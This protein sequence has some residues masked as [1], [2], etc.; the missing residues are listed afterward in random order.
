MVAALAA[1]LLVVL[2]A[3][4]VT[5][6]TAGPA[7]A[8]AT[9]VSTSPAEGEVLA[10]APEQITL[11]FSEPVSLAADGVAVF[12][13]KGAPV[14]ASATS[15]DEQ[16]VAEFDDPGALAD[17]TYVVTWRVISADG[18][19]VAGS[20]TF[21][22]GAPSPSVATPE[23]P[24]GS[25]GAVRAL[26]SVATAVQY[27]G[28]LLAAGL[29]L[30]LTV[31][32]RRQPRVDVAARRLGVVA[33]AAAA[34]GVLGALATLPL[35]LAY[36]SGASVGGVADRETWSAVTTTDLVGTTALLVALGLVALGLP[37]AV[38]RG[39]RTVVQ[40]AALVALVVPTL[41]GH[42]RAFGPEV[43]MV[44][45]DVLHLAAAAI[46]LGG[47]VGLAVTLPSL[48]GRARAA[49]E[50]L[51]RFSTVAAGALLAL[52]AAGL[53]MSWRIVVSWDN[54]TGTDYG[55]LLAA[56]VTLVAVVVAIAAWNRFDLVPEVARSTGHEDGRRAVA[57]VRRSVVAEAAVLVAVVA[58]TGF[59]VNQ[60]P[61]TTLPPVPPGRS[62]TESAV[63]GDVT[64]FATLTPGRTG[65]N[66]L[67]V[68]L[69]DASGEPL[70]HPLPP[71]VRVSSDAVDLGDVPLTSADAGTFS[72]E[73][74]LPSPGLWEVQ[75]G[76]RLSQFEN[77]VGV[78]TFEVR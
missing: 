48:A 4:A 2:G 71:T 63:L 10:D 65:R 26:L 24:T 22:I 1:G 12:D 3:F 39:Q 37:R 33:R 41:T 38:T 27:A 23:P 32:L 14:D 54:L 31:L 52:T 7:A 62:G 40:V 5:L 67:L 29:V 49:A 56:K 66:T 73:V 35:S 44:A 74:T 58:V 47:L 60:T 69:Q 36:R 34:V 6:G 21:S 68:Q 72:G 77:P 61:R 13:A 30:F 46:W 42:T 18:H 50:L 9:L 20:L 16:V 8:H 76:Q 53:L 28:L 75:V 55:L 43:A 15:R 25:P 70:E 45:L 19:P 78:L 17:G 11:A 57:V 64:V 51:T 59:L